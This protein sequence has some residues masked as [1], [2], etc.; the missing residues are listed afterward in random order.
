MFF[1]H[2]V[3]CIIIIDND[4]QIK[5]WKP[6]YTCEFICKHNDSMTFEITSETLKYVTSF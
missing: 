1:F 3:T 4:H 5:R 6:Y 2:W